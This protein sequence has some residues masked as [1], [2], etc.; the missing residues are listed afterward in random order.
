MAF[1]AD[2]D[3]NRKCI[4]AMCVCICCA[5]LQQEQWRLF[6]IRQEYLV[7]QWKTEHISMHLYTY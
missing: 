5:G 7:T 1:S 4:V 6:I 2:G 3:L